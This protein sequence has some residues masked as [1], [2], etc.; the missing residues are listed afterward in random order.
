MGST[1]DHPSPLGDNTQEQTEYDATD[2]PDGTFRCVYDRSGNY[3]LTVVG[4]TRG[5]SRGKRKGAPGAGSS[6]GAASSGAQ[7]Q[8]AAATLASLSKD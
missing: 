3:R 8:E 1:T 5:P 4:S 7:K 2:A 6:S